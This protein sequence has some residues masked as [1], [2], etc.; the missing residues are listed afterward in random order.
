MVNIIFFLSSL[1]VLCLLDLFFLYGGSR[2][3]DQ[4][5]VDV[6]VVGSAG[7]SMREVVC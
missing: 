5:A 4:V 3:E 6:T 1:S 7:L 2:R